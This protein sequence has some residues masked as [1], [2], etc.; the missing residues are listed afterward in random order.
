V[1]GRGAVGAW[2]VALILGGCGGAGATRSPTSGPLAGLPPADHPVHVGVGPRYRLPALSRA[3]VPGRE[4]D[5]LPC[6]RRHP[7]QYGV[8][9]ELFAHR[10]VIPVTAGIGVAPPVRRSGAYVISGRCEYPLRTLEPTGVIRIDRGLPRVPALGTVF[11]LWDQPLSGDALAGFRGRVLAFVDGRRWRAAPGA[12]PLRRH[13]QI[14]LEIDGA[15]PPH[16][17]YE[18]PPGL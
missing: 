3:V 8:H 18:F 13:A 17:R 6:T 7:A 5:G 9:L 15:L 4:V 10:L 11:K 1:A 14:V 16:P 2:V 12:I